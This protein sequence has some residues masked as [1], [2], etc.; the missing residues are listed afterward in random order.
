MVI[1]G[2]CCRPFSPESGRIQ[3]RVLT[4]SKIHKNNHQERMAGEWPPRWHYSCVDLNLKNGW[5]I[6]LCGYTMGLGPYISD[7]RQVSS[8]HLKFPTNHYNNLSALQ[9][10]TICHQTTTFSHK[11]NSYLSGLFGSDW[12]KI[13]RCSWW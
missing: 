7:G 3:L 4:Y 2:T 11:K 1:I 8:P 9:S 6:I 12:D 10:I 5:G 13:H